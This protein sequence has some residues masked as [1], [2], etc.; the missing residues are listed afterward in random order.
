MLGDL[1]C[2]VR[3]GA[4]IR[5]IMLEGLL[6]AIVPRTAALDGGRTE[7]RPLEL[8][9]KALAYGLLKIFMRKFQT[10]TEKGNLVAAWRWRLELSATGGRTS[11][12]QM[13]CG[14]MVTM[15]TNL[16]SMAIDVSILA[17]RS[18]L[19]LARCGCEC[20]TFLSAVVVGV[21]VSAVVA[22]PRRS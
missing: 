5:G 7:A 9:R 1:T 18:S 14:T 20:A 10:G 12:G 11:K 19:H 16:V 6:L 3:G 22:S 8:I 21:A 2:Q 17:A 15:I 4:T 13:A